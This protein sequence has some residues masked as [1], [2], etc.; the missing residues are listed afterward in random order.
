[1]LK[2]E[3][4]TSG[5]RRESGFVTRRAPDRSSWQPVIFDAGSALDRSKLE[6]LL[7][8]QSAVRCM[9]TIDQQLTDYARTLLKDKQAP[10][11]LVSRKVEEVLNG[12][13]PE[14]VG[15][16]VY[17]P[18][19][20][21]VTHLLPK[22]MFRELRLDRN[23]HRITRDEQAVL[24]EKSIGIVGLSVGVSGLVTMVLEGVGGKFRIADFDA[25]DLSNLNRLRASVLDVGINKA[26]LAARAILEIDPYLDV[27]IFPEG[28]HMGNVEAFFA[29]PLDVLV[30]ECDDLPMK[31]RLRE[32]A[33]S[34][35]IPVL[36]ETTDRGMLD[37]ERF[38]LEPQR[39]IFHGRVGN[40]DADS[41]QHASM[42]DRVPFFL[43]IVDEQ[44]MSTR[45]AA[46]LVEIEKTVYT[47]PQLASAVALGGALLSFAARNLL[48]GVHRF[49][50]RLY[51]DFDNLIERDVLFTDAS[52]APAVSERPRAQPIERPC[53]SLP[54][55][56]TG[57][58]TA[59]EARFLVEHAVC[60]PSGGN[61]QPW[62]FHH[63]PGEIECHRVA[64]RGNTFLDFGGWAS[65]V[66]IGAAVENIAIAAACLGYQI[67]VEEP[68]QPAGPVARLKFLPGA[69]QPDSALRQAIFDRVTHRH[70]LQQRPLPDDV[71]A[72]L[73][74]Q[75]RQLGLHLVLVR[76]QVRLR[77]LGLILGLSDRLRLQIR[78]YHAEMMSEVR[79]NA[80]ESQRDRTGIDIASLEASAADAAGMHVVRRWDVMQF[81]ADHGLG[82]SLE[83]VARKSAV[84]CAG[85]ALLSNPASMS[86]LEAGRRLQ[87]L[88]LH[89][90]LR[91]L[92][93]HPWLAIL[94][95][96]ARAKTGEGLSSQEQQ[97]ITGVAEKL[98][99]LWRLPAG[100][101]PLFVSRILENPPEPS[102]RSGRLPMEAIF[103][104]TS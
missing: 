28:I 59:S 11:Q 71:S 90:T 4:D 51:V 104:Q 34:A 45:L 44:R 7:E 68:A 32:Y 83:D 20:D 16:W 89:S 79:W 41:L 14:E 76:D 94:A 10:Q 84:A 43:A 52:A 88:W 103:D 19:R 39:P 13:A 102:A 75:A 97:S 86:T 37:V 69:R 3:A 92:A 96:H 64:E 50:G 54:S 31:V 93:W 56:G 5:G 65:R 91:G 81:L 46:S 101:V 77:E 58:L 49:S 17:Y 53:P 1:M 40:V 66:A 74:Q 18:W 38:D 55:S 9:D 99:G 73:E 60:A 48:L 57:Q 47:W 63:R 61:S 29:P 100:H 72:E 12:L 42:R 30:E 8:A 33:R 35:G 25:L 36:M 62:R 6:A 27:E 85:I 80:E 82:E 2:P 67:L 26:V 95:M 24:L 98:L 70:Q 22:G 87:R 15:C 23:R 21:Q 78:S